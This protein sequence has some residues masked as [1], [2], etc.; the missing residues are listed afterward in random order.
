[1]REHEKLAELLAEASQQVRYNIDL[2]APALS[3]D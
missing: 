1:M 2:M 3:F